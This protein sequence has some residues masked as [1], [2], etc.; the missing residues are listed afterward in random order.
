MVD[1]PPLSTGL[2]PGSTDAS[3]GDVAHWLWRSH[4]AARRVVV[5]TITGFVGPPGDVRPDVPTTGKWLCH[6]GMDE[7]A[8]GVFGLFEIPRLFTPPAED[9]TWRAIARYV[10]YWSGWSLLP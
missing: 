2:D 6:L 8:H 4:F 9:E 3:T 1:P 10:H 7:C 5:A